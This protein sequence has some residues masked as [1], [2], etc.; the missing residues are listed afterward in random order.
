MSDGASLHR[1]WPATGSVVIRHFATMRTYGKNFIYKKTVNYQ[2]RQ[3]R[4]ATEW[5]IRLDVSDALTVENIISNIKEQL[6]DLSFV[7]VSGVERPDMEKIEGP[8]RE[9]QTVVQPVNQYGSKEHHVHLCLVLFVPRQRADVLKLV[10]GP[11]KMADEYCAPRNAKFPYAGWVIHHAKPAFKL[12]G[13]PDIRFERGDLP[14][15]PFTSDWALKI[16]SLMTKWG[17]PAMEQRFKGYLDLLRK[18]KI[19]EKIEQLQM[20]L[21]D[22]NAN[23]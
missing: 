9:D 5:D 13:E 17:T 19:Q 6:D 1:F 3:A 10:R 23:C 18:N 4:L 12:D 16:K 2:Q 14:M 20:S 21:E 7:L 15:D 22:N 8:R 11:R